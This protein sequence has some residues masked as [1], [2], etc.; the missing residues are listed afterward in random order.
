MIQPVGIYRQVSRG[1]ETARLLDPVFSGLSGWR[2]A[3]SAA[4]VPIGISV[5]RN[6]KIDTKLRAGRR[7]KPQSPWLSSCQ[8]SPNPACGIGLADWS[9]K[10]RKTHGF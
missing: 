1:K 10:P 8:E 7:H 6:L 9:I 5:L 4:T 2:L 3:S